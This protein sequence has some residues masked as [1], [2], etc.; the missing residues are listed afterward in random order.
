MADDFLGVF[1]GNPARAKVL[2][3]FLFNQADIL[4][5]AIVAKRA[6]VSAQIAKREI[7]VLEHWGVL[8]PV[9][10]VITVPQSTKKVEG[11]QKEEAWTIDTSFKHALALSKFVHEISPMQHGYVL[12]ALK[13]VARVGVAVLSGVFVGDPSRPVDIILAGDGVNEERLE[14]AI[15]SIEPQLGRE[16]RYTLFST[17][18]FRYRL[19]IQDR[20]VRETLDYPHVILFDKA[21]LLK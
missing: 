2:R 16:L 18:E 20:L 13:R 21:N 1:I 7:T 6:G 12:A 4:T 9:K 11:K 5:T 3:V 19:T 10:F 17:T 14:H 15:R 8:K